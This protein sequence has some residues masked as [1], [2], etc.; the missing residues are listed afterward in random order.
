MASR[1]PAF[2]V[3]CDTSILIKVFLG[4]QVVVKSHYFITI[5]GVREVYLS[6]RSLNTSGNGCLSQ[7]EFCHVYDVLDMKWKECEDSTDWFDRCE[8]PTIARLARHTH[9]L[10][11]ST[12]FNYFVCKFHVV[13]LYEIQA[14]LWLK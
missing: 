8:W 10:V 5:L 11:T 3:S 1:C 7:S 14:K 4:S 9:R 6:F 12:F 13:S 2:V